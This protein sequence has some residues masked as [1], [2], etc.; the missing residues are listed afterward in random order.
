MII[1]ILIEACDVVKQQLTLSDF[2][3][4]RGLTLF[5]I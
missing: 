2:S 1:N 3:S 5:K 4:R